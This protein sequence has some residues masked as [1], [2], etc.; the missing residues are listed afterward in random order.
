VNDNAAGPPGL[1]LVGEIILDRGESEKLV[2]DVGT[3]SEGNNRN[4]RD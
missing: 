2:N 4:N 1:E 3:K